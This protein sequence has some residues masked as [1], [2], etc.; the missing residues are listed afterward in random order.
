VTDTNAIS[1]VKRAGVWD[2]RTQLAVQQLVNTLKTN[3][4]WTN[5]VAFYPFVGG[6]SNSCAQNLVSTQYTIGW[7]DTNGTSYS[8]SS[9]YDPSN[10]VFKATGVSDKWDDASGSGWGGGWSRAWGNTEFDDTNWF[11]TNSFHIYGWVNNQYTNGLGYMGNNL[12]TSGARLSFGIGAS[13]NSPCGDVFS[14]DIPGGGPPVGGNQLVQRLISTNI[15][16]SDYTNNSI[17]ATATNKATPYRLLVLRGNLDSAGSPAEMRAASFGFAFTL[18]QASNYF[19][20]V[21][22]FQNFL[23]RGNP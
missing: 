11:T 17:T 23:G 16:I 2:L 7:G 19:S 14:G 4:C 18:S 3:N 15:F 6:N 21:Q 22:A 13:T 5:L 1:F 8:P 20:A 12:G 10:I 9:R